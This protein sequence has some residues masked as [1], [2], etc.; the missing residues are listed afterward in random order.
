MN[1]QKLSQ[2]VSHGYFRVVG[3]RFQESAI[4]V[5]LMALGFFLD[6]FFHHGH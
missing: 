1:P 2:R 4:W 3:C 6:W 5:G